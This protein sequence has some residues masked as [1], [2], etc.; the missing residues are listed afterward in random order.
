MKAVAFPKVKMHEKS[1]QALFKKA[2]KLKAEYH[3]DALHQAAFFSFIVDD[4]IVGHML[5]EDV[6]FFSYMQAPGKV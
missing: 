1:H 4:I 3:R 5:K 2:L 6:Q